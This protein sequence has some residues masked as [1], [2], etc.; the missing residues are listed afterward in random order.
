M[1][2]RSRQLADSTRTAILLV[3]CVVFVATTSGLL[4]AVHLLCAGHS[5]GHDSHDCAVCQQFLTTSKKPALAPSE[6]PG[7]IPPVICRAERLF[8]EHI[9]SRYPQA[10]QSRG[11]PA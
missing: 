8:I 2:I 4:L 1:Q 3:A 7:C 11:P 10:S 5:A 6:E 9:D